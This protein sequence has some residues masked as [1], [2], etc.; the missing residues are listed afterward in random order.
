MSR[1]A[2]IVNRQMLFSTDDRDMARRFQAMDFEIYDHENGC[3]TCIGHRAMDSRDLL[4]EEDYL[5]HW[6]S[7]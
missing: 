1:W 7:H 3:Y 5:E 2:I 6:Q 4:R